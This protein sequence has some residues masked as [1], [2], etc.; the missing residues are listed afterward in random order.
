M[1]SS[2]GTDDRSRDDHGTCDRRRKLDIFKYYVAYHLIEESLEE[3]D[4]A[5]DTFRESA[6]QRRV[7]N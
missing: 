7:T 2:R 1:D 4:E 5:K 6:R 3:R